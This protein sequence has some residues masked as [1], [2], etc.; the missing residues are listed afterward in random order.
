MK[1]II[2]ILFTISIVFCI[3]SNS[4]GA[5]SGNDDASCGEN[6]TWTLTDGILTVSGVGSMDSVP[7]EED[8]Q[9]INTVLIE[10]GVTNIYECAFQDCI[11]LKEIIIADSV[12]EIDNWAFDGCTLLAEVDMPQELQRLGYFAFSDCKNLSYIEISEGVTYIDEGTFMGCEKLSSVVLPDGVTEIRTEAFYG[13]TSLEGIILPVGV[14]EIAQGAFFGCSGLVN[15][16]IPESVEFVDNWAFYECKQ[17][18]NVSYSGTEEEWNDIYFGG[19]NNNLTETSNIRFSAKP[20]LSGSNDDF[21]YIN[22]NGVLKIVSCYLNENAVITIPEYIGG[23]RVTEIGDNAFSNCTAMTDIYI[24]KSVSAIA[25]NAFLGCESLKTVYFL[26]TLEEW[27]KIVIDSGNENLLNAFL[28]HDGIY[29]GKINENISWMFQNGVVTVNGTGGLPVFTSSSK[30]GWCDSEGSSEITKIVIGDGITRVGHGVFSW[31]ENLETA[32]FSKD[33][34]FIDYNTFYNSPNLK[35]VIVSDE[36]SVYSSKDGVLFDKDQTELMFCPPGKNADMYVI[37]ETVIRL[38]YMAFHSCNNIRGITISDNVTEAEAAVFFE[39]ENL[40]TVILGSGLTHIRPSMFKGCKSLKSIMIPGNIIGI[41]TEAFG[42]CEKLEEIETTGN[43]IIVGDLAFDNTAFYNNESNWEND[44]L[45]LDTCLI[46]ARQ[47][48]NGEYSIREGTKTIAGSAFSGCQELTGITMPDNTTIIGPYAFSGCINLSK[49]NLSCNLQRIWS[50]FRGCKSLT[51]I[52]IPDGITILENEAF[53]NCESLQ[54]ITIPGSVSE[55]EKE[56]FLGCTNLK[57]IYYCGSGKQWKSMKIGIDNDALNDAVIHYIGEFLF[58]TETKTLTILHDGSLNGYSSADEVPW[59]EYKDEVKS[60]IISEDVTNIC[61]YAFSDYQGIISIIIPDSVTVI[62]NSAF[63]GCTGLKKI[64]IPKSVTEIK[65]AAFFGCA[66]LDTVEIPSSVKSIGRMAF[67]GCEKLSE[68]NFGTGIGT[69]GGYAF[70]GDI[71]LKTVIYQGSAEEWKNVSIAP[72]ND[73]LLN[74]DIS[75]AIEKIIPLDISVHFASSFSGNILTVNVIAESNEKE[76]ITAYV[77]AAVYGKDGI[78]KK[79]EM[80]DV[81]ISADNSLFIL[82]NMDGYV[83]ENGD[84]IKLFL[85]KD[86]IN[87]RPLIEANVQS[88][89]VSE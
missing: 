5:E 70:S 24:P 62:G 89:T 65:S 32:E 19:Y 30:P 3:T 48:L 88:I 35:S 18:M 46:K 6:L 33:V 20:Q 47:S 71:N 4:L 69:I 79:N 11:N 59:Y 17:L 9:K 16:F 52:E 85:W 64:T 60:I 67:G 66:S 57:D 56:A 8:K 50:A 74:A 28:Y 86:L 27:K 1:L 54:K 25:E 7:W 83:Y 55:I 41:G 22:E 75:Y 58:N 15:I 31:L 40:E 13:C 42:N 81:T 68:I 14:K 77:I 82:L 39:C 76:N 45:Y 12:M 34:E 61:D 78:V 29:G 87:A 63:S 23:G 2:K 80:K 43:E 72:G 10:N 49:V 26:G 21:S 53:V 51:D 37:P 36:N 44:V 84:Y 73:E 38:K